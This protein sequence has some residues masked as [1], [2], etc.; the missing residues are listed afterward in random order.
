L[1]NFYVARQKFDNTGAAYKKSI[2][3]DSSFIAAYINLADLYRLQDKDDDAN[4]VI[5][6]AKQIAA[7]NADIYYALGL[8]LI[9]QKKM[10]KPFEN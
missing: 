1:G 8:S 4:K 2:A 7:D 6:S 10:R 5:K 3:L 9:R